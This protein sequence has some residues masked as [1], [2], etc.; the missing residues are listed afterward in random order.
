M[1]FLKES[2]RYIHGGANPCYVFVDNHSSL[3]TTAHLSWAGR[4]LVTSMLMM[5]E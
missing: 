1:D 4:S 2:L 5:E 3:L